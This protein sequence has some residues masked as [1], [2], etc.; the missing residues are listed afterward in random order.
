M[1]AAP[2]EDDTTSDDQQYVHVPLPRGF[3]GWRWHLLDAKDRWRSFAHRRWLPVRNAARALRERPLRRLW[4]RSLVH[5]VTADDVREALVFVRDE[6]IIT[7]A[8]LPLRLRM[9]GTPSDDDLWGLAFDE[10][11]YRDSIATY[12]SA[13]EAARRLEFAAL[14]CFADDNMMGYAS[15]RAQAGH[16]LNRPE[17]ADG[18]GL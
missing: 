4:L 9:T 13:E 17:L 10:C 3:L 6:G 7:V 16:L 1:H 12:G 15:F 11:F 18:G 14:S 5:P 2:L 8:A